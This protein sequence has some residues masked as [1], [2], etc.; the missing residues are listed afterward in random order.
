MRTP[1][2]RAD[3]GANQGPTQG[4]NQGPTQGANQGPTQG[5][6]AHRRNGPKTLAGPGKFR[7]PAVPT[8]PYAH[9]LKSP[10]GLARSDEGAGEVR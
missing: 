3:Q 1:E 8:T 7:Y 9:D 4:A 6:S 5:A 2:G 10:K